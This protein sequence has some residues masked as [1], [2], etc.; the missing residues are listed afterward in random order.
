MLDDIEDRILAHPESVALDRA[1]E[2]AKTN[3][4]SYAWVVSR[5]E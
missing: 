1:P 5:F 4:V 2:L 3:A